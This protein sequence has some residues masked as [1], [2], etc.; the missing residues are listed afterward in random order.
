[1]KTKALMQMFN[2]LHTCKIVSEKTSW[3]VSTLWL[4]VLE[5][6]TGIIELDGLTSSS[7]V[8]MAV[9]SPRTS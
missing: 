4:T 3:I 1:M 2:V 6:M 7:T 8:K 5:S 9:Q